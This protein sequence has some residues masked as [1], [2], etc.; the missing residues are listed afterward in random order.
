M[1][2]GVGLTNGAKYRIVSWAYEMGMP[3]MNIGSSRTSELHIS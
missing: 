2:V 3:E 1:A